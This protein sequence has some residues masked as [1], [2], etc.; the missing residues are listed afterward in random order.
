MAPLKVEYEFLEYFLL[1]LLSL[2]VYLFTP[3]PLPAMATLFYCSFE[4]IYFIHFWSNLWVY[5]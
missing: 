3:F 5:L 2:V 4:F 1:Y